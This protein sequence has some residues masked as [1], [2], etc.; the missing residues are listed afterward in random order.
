MFSIDLNCRFAASRFG[1]TNDIMGI[2]NELQN[3][4]ECLRIFIAAY[5]PA[6]DCDWANKGWQLFIELICKHQLKYELI[7]NKTTN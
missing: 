5:F 6:C 1:L 4:M 3:Q 2:A 7:L